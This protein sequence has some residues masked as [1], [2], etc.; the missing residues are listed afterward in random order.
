MTRNSC[1][2]LFVVVF[3]F[4]GHPLRANSQESISKVY[5]HVFELITTDQVSRVSIIHVPTYIETRMRIDQQTLRRLSNVE[6]VFANPKEGN[7]LNGLQSAVGELRTAVRAPEREVR[8]GILLFD[9]TGKERAAIFLDSTGRFVQVGD[10][11][12]QVR[13]ATLAWIRKTIHASLE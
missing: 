12:L 6:V 3:V 7:L 2:A 10:I 9:V 13:G 1:V 5:D 4:F 11:R 8:W